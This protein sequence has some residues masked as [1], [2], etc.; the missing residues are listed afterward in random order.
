MLLAIP[1][2]L[3]SDLTIGTYKLYFKNVLDVGAIPELILPFDV[4]F[5]NKLVT[6]T[7]TIPDPERKTF[8]ITLIVKENPIPVLAILAGV[9]ILFGLT[10]GYMTL[11][12]IEKIIDS[13]VAQVGILA[14][15]VGIIFIV[16]RMMKR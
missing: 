9:L 11:D 15:A 16:A 5:M 14:V 6:I 13:P 8:I 3:T 2:P 4:K 1:V 12:K 7:E 10:I